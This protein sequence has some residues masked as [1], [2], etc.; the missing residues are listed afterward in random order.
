MISELNSIPYYDCHYQEITFKENNKNEN[1]QES[2]DYYLNCFADFSQSE[3]ESE[4]F[5]EKS[6]MLIEGSKIEQ[7]I[8]SKYTKES[9]NKS[10]IISQKKENKKEEKTFLDLKTISDIYKSEISYLDYNL[11]LYLIKT[12]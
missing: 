8:S 4:E 6:I 1:N 3:K 7:N 12:I 11:N 5:N 2:M 10:E 9:Y